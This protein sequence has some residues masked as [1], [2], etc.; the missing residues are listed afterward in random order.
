[1]AVI[2]E[3]VD[4]SGSSFDV[5]GNGWS[6]DNTWATYT[7]V[8]LIYY[9]EQWYWDYAKLVHI[10]TVPTGDKILLGYDKEPGLDRHRHPGPHYWDECTQL[11]GDLPV[12][13]H[14]VGAG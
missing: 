5:F 10:S 7:A 9:H 8:H 4:L 3:K 11:T 12:H 14:L 6:P 2:N 1:M 13:S